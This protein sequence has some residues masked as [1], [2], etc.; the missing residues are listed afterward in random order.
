MD[1]FC[2]YCNKKLTSAQRKNKYCSQECAVKAKRDEKIIAWLSGEDDGLRGKE[3]LSS[4]IRNYLLEKNNYKCELCDW[5]EVNSYTGKTPLE[6]HHIDGNYLNNK[7]DNLQVLCPNCHSLTSSYKAL[8][9]NGREYRTQSRKNYCC[10]CGKE[11]GANSKRCRQCND[12]KRV[13][14]KPISREELKTKIRILPFTTIA[15]EY[16][17]SDNA[18]RKWCIG[19][20]LPSKKKDIKKYSDEEWKNI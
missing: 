8:N 15:T 4:T 19:Y 2:L 18:I 1:K 17:V 13:T 10:D 9:K 11:I 3:Q 14:E 16:N 5:G 12:K 7:K 6:I 20:D